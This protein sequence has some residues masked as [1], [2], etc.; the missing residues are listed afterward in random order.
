MQ[1]ELAGVDLDDP[2]LM[3]AVV[4]TSR[5]AYVYMYMCGLYGSI[6]G[7]LALD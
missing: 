1:A 3:N 7:R 2:A 4:L 6:G 5:Y